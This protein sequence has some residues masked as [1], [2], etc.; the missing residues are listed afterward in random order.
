MSKPFKRIGLIAKQRA[1]SR[2]KDTLEN[3]CQFLLHHKKQITVETETLQFLPNSNFPTATINDLG[4]YCDLMIVVGGDGSLLHATRAALPHDVPMIGINRGRLGFLTDIRPNEIN[5]LLAAVLEGEYIEETRFLLDARIFHDKNVLTSDMALNDVVLTPGDVSHMIEFE[6]FIN[7]EFV[8]N[9]RADGIIVATP[10]GSTAYALSGGGPIIH[11]QLNAIVL[12]PMFPHTLSSRPIVIDSTSKIN[13]IV[14]KTN[15]SPCHLSC[16][17]QSFVLVDP[18]DS[19]HIEKKRQ[20]LRLIHPVN[21]QYFETLR[22]KL[23][24]SKSYLD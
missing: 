14:S 23:H 1:H 18:G 8:L 20:K 2:I 13:I 11:P 15:E 24:W 21:Y 16:D 19:I 6:I 12:V 5:T 9:Q 3:L 7:D 22:D 10:T 4:K 17:G